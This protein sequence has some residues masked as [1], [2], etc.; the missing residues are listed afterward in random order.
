MYFPFFFPCT[1]YTA[2]DEGGVRVDLCGQYWGARSRRV[3]GSEYRAAC[4]RWK[5]LWMALRRASL[6]LR[7]A[8]CWAS[9]EHTVGAMLPPQSPP[10]ALTS[11]GGSAVAPTL[12]AA[13][14]I[15]LHSD[16]KVQPVYDF[17]LQN[18]ELQTDADVVSIHEDAGWGI[19]WR[20]FFTPAVPAP[21]VWA[22]HIAAMQGALES[23]VWRTA[24]GSFLTL[25]LVNNGL[26][27]TCPAANVTEAGGSDPFIGPTTGPCTGCYEFDPTRNPEAALVR[28]AHLKYVS[29]M[30]KA[31]RP[32]Y[33]CH[34][35]EVNMYA[36]ACS[37]EQWASVVEFAN[38]VYA[39]AKQANASLKVFPSFQA[40]FLRGEV[41][42]GDP[43]RGKPVT[44]CIAT[45]KAQIAPLRRDLFALSAYPSFLGPPTGGSFANGAAN[46]TFGGRLASSF[47]GYLEPILA[48][49]PH[50]AERLAIA[51]T[52]AIATNVTVQVDSGSK[53]ECVT[54]L[55]SDAHLAAGWLQ[56]LVNVAKA[57]ASGFE[58]LTWWSDADY[59][60]ASVEVE[61][62]SKACSWPHKTAPYCQ[63]I[64][65]FRTVYKAK[66]GEWTGEL[67]LKEFGTMGLRQYD[68]TPR[69][70]LFEVWRQL[71]HVE[72]V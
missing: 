30:V 36:S 49:L 28:A 38:D 50:A 57:S 22:R 5:H 72:P 39:A 61:C 26:G 60:P 55:Q 63:I 43:C 32:R 71:R 24:H 1:R 17:N 42:D 51:E 35:P 69:P 68:L 10:A 62:F 48:T 21:A 37:A 64:D 19:P 65:L 29:M 12:L 8:A 44:P 25:S 4:W 15:Q 41:N 20:K 13:T 58:L 47:D 56:Y 18:A 53:H 31:L 7:I 16:I 70:E 23:G 27:R 11:P 52:G 54:L 40:A 67:V 34:A 6:L 2:V 9:A 14:A 3:P 45:A 33:L 59:M 66:G 46:F